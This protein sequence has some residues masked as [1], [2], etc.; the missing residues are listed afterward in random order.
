[1][2]RS[3][4]RPVSCRPASCVRAQ[5]RK[6]ELMTRFSEPPLALSFHPSGLHMIVSFPDKIRLCNL[7][8]DEVRPFKEIAIKVRACV[9]ACERACRRACGRA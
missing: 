1:M 8:Y 6:L 5:E 2:F 9:R 3:L 7:I 4:R